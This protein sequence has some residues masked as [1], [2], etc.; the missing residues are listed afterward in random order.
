M[1]FCLQ[2]ASA[3][4]A[5]GSGRQLPQSPTFVVGTTSV[6]AAVMMP[7]RAPILNIP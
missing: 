6:D 3:P 7:Y 2:G 1:G 4:F 5:L